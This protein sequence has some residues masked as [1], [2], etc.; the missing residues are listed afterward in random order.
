MS[1]ETLVITAVSIISW[2]TDIC[3]YNKIEYKKKKQDVYTKVFFFP[4]TDVDSRIVRCN[5]LREDT[6]SESLHLLSAKRSIDDGVK[7]RIFTCKNNTGEQRDF[8]Q[9]QIKKFRRNGIEVRTHSSKFLMHHKFAIIDKEIVITGTL[10]WTLKAL[11]HNHENVVITNEEN[12]T[13][14]Y[15]NEFERLWNTLKNVKFL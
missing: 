5:N 4:D 1:K 12:I 13:K 14:A 6:S 3:A 10:N 2:V 9:A 8:A 15:I 11:T 7:V